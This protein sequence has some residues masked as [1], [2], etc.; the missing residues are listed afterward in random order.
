MIRRPPRSTLFPYTTLFR[1]GPYSRPPASELVTQP[2][3]ELVDT[4]GP[5]GGHGQGNLALLLTQGLELLQLLM[6]HVDIRI[7]GVGALALAFVEPDLDGVQ[8]SSA[9]QN[10]AGNALIFNGLA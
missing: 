2:F 9:M 6:H 1:S 4:V 8:R 7:G 3:C 10:D 5:V